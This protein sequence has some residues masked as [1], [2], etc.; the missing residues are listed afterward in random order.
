M[1][2]RKAAF[3]YSENYCHQF[4]FFCHITQFSTFIVVDL[5]SHVCFLTAPVEGKHPGLTRLQLSTFSW[6]TVYCNKQIL[7]GQKEGL[8]TEACKAS[9]AV[10]R[11]SAEEEKRLMNFLNSSPPG[12]FHISLP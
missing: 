12:V 7:G 5:Y 6:H 9:S 4:F 10:G 3:D 11:Q 8:S 1:I 2:I